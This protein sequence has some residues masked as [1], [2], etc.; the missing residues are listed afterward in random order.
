MFMGLLTRTTQQSQR[1]NLSVG[2]AAS[3]AFLPFVLGGRQ[4]QPVGL[5]NYYPLQTSR[6]RISVVQA[7]PMRRFCL[8]PG[9]LAALA[10]AQRVRGQAGRKYL[11][12]PHS[13]P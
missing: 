6:N 4:A 1:R 8:H 7:G 2:T 3:E 11:G 12:S 10:L 9:V 13:R 5:G